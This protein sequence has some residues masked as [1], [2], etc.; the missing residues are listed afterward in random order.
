MH[1]LRGGLLAATGVAVAFPAGFVQAQQKFPSK[2]IPLILEIVRVLDL[3]DVREP[4]HAMGFVPA[5]STPEEYE[6]IVRSQIASLSK[7][8]SEAGLR[9]K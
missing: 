1:A 6:K 3:P 9:P 5:P 2:P 7:L 8:A 4:M